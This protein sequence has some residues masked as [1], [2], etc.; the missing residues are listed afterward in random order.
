MENKR[1]LTIDLKQRNHGNSMILQIEDS[2]ENLPM[3]LDLDVAEALKKIKEYIMNKNFQESEK[4][5]ERIAPY[6]RVNK[7]HDL[8]EEYSNL[9]DTSYTLSNAS[10]WM[11][12]PNSL[13]SYLWLRR[14]YYYLVAIKGSKKIEEFQ[15][16]YDE[17]HSL[18]KVYIDEYDMMATLN[19]F[20]DMLASD[21][22]IPYVMGMIDSLSE[23]YLYNET[24]RNFLNELIEQ[25]NKLRNKALISF[26]NNEG[27]IRNLKFLFPYE[28]RKIFKDNR[29]KLYFRQLKQTYT[30]YKKLKVDMKYMYQLYTINTSENFYSYYNNII[31]VNVEN[32]SELEEYY[33]EY[34]CRKLYE[35]KVKFYTVKELKKTIDKFIEKL[36]IKEVKNILPI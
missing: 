34:I 7:N 17:I 25:V 35:D 31:A 29:V 4:A 1:I 11:S 15:G 3:V 14:T 24:Q 19:S 32:F 23:I 8:M 28:Y 22:N 27:K 30:D 18:I 20:K 12:N 10:K 6:L 2:R 36:K 9:G 16:I 5:I 13:E 33:K 21:S 26:N